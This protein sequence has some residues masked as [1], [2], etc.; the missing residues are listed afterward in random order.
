VLC[1]RTQWW[2]GFQLVCNNLNGVSESQCP[3][4]VVVALCLPKKPRS[5]VSDCNDAGPPGGGAGLAADLQQQ[6]PQWDGTH[7]GPRMPCPSTLIPSPESCIQMP[8][9]QAP[10]T[11]WVVWQ[12]SGLEV[13]VQRLLSSA[14]GDQPPEALKPWAYPVTASSCLFPPCG[15]SASNPLSVCRSLRSALPS[16]HHHLRHAGVPW[17]HCPVRWALSVRVLCLTNTVAMCGG[18]TAHRQQAGGFDQ[19]ELHRPCP[20]PPDSRQVPPPP[21]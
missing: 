19:T 12:S 1:L 5:A 20:H 3:L 15:F 4:E 16:W 17:T 13:R 18:G 14:G 6:Q 2:R 7:G 11:H 9:P 10:G 8:A 21:R